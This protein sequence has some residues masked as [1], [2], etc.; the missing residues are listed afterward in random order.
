MNAEKPKGA[1]GASGMTIGVCMVYGATWNNPL[2]SDD[3][4]VVED[5]IKAISQAFDLVKSILKQG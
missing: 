2:K 3:A 5:Q 1:S 4:P